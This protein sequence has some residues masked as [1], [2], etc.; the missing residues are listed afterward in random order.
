MLYVLN[1]LLLNVPLDTGGR[2]QVDIWR[3]EP[4]RFRKCYS[5]N[6]VSGLSGH[7][8]FL[9]VFC[10]ARVSGPGFFTDGHC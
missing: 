8:L 3:R 9:L 10:L 7:T 4:N 5:E 1:R 6:D 2:K